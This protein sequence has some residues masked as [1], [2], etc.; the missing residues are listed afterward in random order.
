MNLILPIFLFFGVFLALCDYSDALRNTRTSRYD[1][2]RSR[3][4]A[5]RNPLARSALR[6]RRPTSGSR[7]ASQLRVMS[8]RRGGVNAAT[9]IKNTKN[10]D[11]KHIKQTIIIAKTANIMSPIG[12]Q[13]NDK[14]AISSRGSGGVQNSS[15]PRNL[16]ISSTRNRI[17]QAGNRR[18]F[19]RNNGQASP[20]ASRAGSQMNGRLGASGR[21]VGSRGFGNR[22][23]SSLGHQGS[24]GSRF[25]N[26]G[27]HGSSLGGHGGSHGGQGGQFGGNGGS[28][29]G[30]G[31]SFG[32][33]GGSTGGHG[34]SFGGNGGS[35]GG[36][37]GSFGG[38]GGSLGGHGGSFGGNGGSLG[39][40]GGS[41]GGNG[42]SLGGHGG[43]FGGNGASMG[44]HGGSFGGNGG[45]LGGHGGSF[46]GNG[47]PLGGRGGVENHGSNTGGHGVGSSSGIAHGGSHPS[48]HASPQNNFRSVQNNLGQSGS[49]SNFNIAD[50]LL[51]GLGVASSSPNLLALM[52]S[53][54]LNAGGGTNG[55]AS[56]AATVPD[57]TGLFRGKEGATLL[58]SLVQNII[59]NG[60]GMGVTAPSVMTGP[61]SLPMISHVGSGAQASKTVSAGGGQH[62]PII[63]EAGSNIQVGFR[64]TNGGPNIV[65]KSAATTTPPPTFLAS[66]TAMNLPALGMELG[67]ELP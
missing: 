12:T 52:S 27:G 47:G 61:T 67:E 46:G 44:G 8:R 54:T 60:G 62:A 48:N 17:L 50:M 6:A 28:M 38:N 23:P 37:G 66:A 26:S 65:I 49:S 3:L 16:A 36:H 9:S 43:S 20:A 10:S 56:N 41:F 4:Q 18:P 51:S 64:H 22:H 2:R 15:P 14:T 59:G 11:T 13:N 57:L 33:N 63:I 42:G 5:M 34:G 35:L 25:G 58:N 30:R 55:M 40:H 7:R 21:G 53:G 45:S 29:S 24:L 31:G 1:P 32:G 39:G 19:R